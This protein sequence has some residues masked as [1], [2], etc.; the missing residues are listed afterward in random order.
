M[1]PTLT[2]SPAYNRMAA[3]ESALRRAATHQRRADAC[4][5]ASSRELFEGCARREMETAERLRNA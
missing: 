5:T 2:T 1:T 3:I 4:D